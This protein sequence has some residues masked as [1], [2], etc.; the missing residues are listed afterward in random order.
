MHHVKRK[1]D[2]TMLSFAKPIS[3]LSWAPL[4]GGRRNGIRFVVNRTLPKNDLRP[5]PVLQA[6]TEQFIAERGMRLPETVAMLTTASQ[7]FLGCSIA[8]NNKGLLMVALCTVGLGNAVA[9]G[10]HAAYDE[11]RG[12]TPS[13]SGTINIILTLNRN[14]TENAALEL[15]HTMAMAKASIMVE[16]GL[17]NRHGQ[18]KLATGTDCQVLCWDQDHEITLAYAGMHTRLAELAAG[19]VRKAMLE[20]MA[21][22][23]GAE[24]SNDSELLRL[25]RS[26]FTAT[27]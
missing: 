26:R 4:G 27:R 15:M 12:Q 16:L 10:D 8:R 2:F 11:E 19:A 23:L 9:P 17:V 21:K 7:K 5:L 22:R 24:Y 3:C 14:L 20:S 25:A 1:P 18:L 13:S 6:D